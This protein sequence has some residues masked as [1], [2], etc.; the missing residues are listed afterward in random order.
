MLVEGL[1]EAV[2]MF[3][4]GD[5]GEATKKLTGKKSFILINQPTKCSFQQLTNKAI[6]NFHWIFVGL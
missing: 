4:F 2:M 3:S 5:G 6:I 1:A